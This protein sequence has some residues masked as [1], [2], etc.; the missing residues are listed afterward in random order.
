MKNLLYFILNLTFPKFE[1]NIIEILKD[2][3]NLVIF[4]IGCY[5]GVFTNNI[6]KLLGNRR[7]KFFLFDINKNVKNYINYLSKKKNI[8]Y[9]EIA[10][11]SKNGT[12]TYNYNSAFESSGSSLASIYKN[13]SKWVNSRNLI[14]KFLSPNNKK[15]GFIKYQVKTSTLDSFFKRKK[16]KSIDIL[17]IDV[18]GSETELLQGAKKTLKNNKIKTILVEISAK[19][20]LYKKKEKKIINFL[21]KNNFVFI[22]KSN[23]FSVSIFSN[24]KCGDYLFVSNKYQIN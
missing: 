22:K 15:K 14:L 20:N 23:I 13:D 7:Y 10:L 6:L 18:D 12:S 21:K 24:V 9:H 16:I 17:K 8:N 5:K 1:K 3:K 19:K 11:T 4:D 2:E